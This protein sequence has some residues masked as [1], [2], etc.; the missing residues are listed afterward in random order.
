MQIDYIT[1]IGIFFILSCLYYTYIN[2]REENK[3]IALKIVSKSR[4]TDAA[5]NFIFTMYKMK[6]LAYSN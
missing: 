2:V 1:Y 6:L 4:T 5:S 3:L